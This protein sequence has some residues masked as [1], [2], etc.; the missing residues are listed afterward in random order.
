VALLHS[1]T[2]IGPRAA[3]WLALDAFRPFATSLTRKRNQHIAIHDTSGDS[4]L[5]V[6]WDASFLQASLD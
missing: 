3:A 1:R 5:L 2:R 6:T 4:I